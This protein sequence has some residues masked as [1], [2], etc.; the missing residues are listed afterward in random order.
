MPRHGR[1][2]DPHRPRR[3]EVENRLGQAHTI[4]FA[5]DCG[6]ILTRRHKPSRPV[7][8]GRPNW[9]HWARVTVARYERKLAKA[10]QRRQR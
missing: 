9:V 2:A 8:G 5:C 7:Y 6:L 10:R 4:G 3:L 1:P